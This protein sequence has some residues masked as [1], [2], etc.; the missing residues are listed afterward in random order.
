MGTNMESV[1]RIET[2]AAGSV[3]L[4]IGHCRL[5]MGGR[6][7]EHL[8]EELQRAVAALGDLKDAM[9]PS[10]LEE[11]E[12]IDGGPAAVGWT[13]SRLVTPLEGALLSV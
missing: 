4:T 13:A 2:R 10:R 6:S 8:A 3:V 1:L 9:V 11:L 5:E 12:D 7:A